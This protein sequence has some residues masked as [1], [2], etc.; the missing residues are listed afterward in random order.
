MNVWSHIYSIQ[1]GKIAIEFDCRLDCKISISDD[2]LH[3]LSFNLQLNNPLHIEVTPELK[4]L[5]SIKKGMDQDDEFARDD[6]TLI[7]T[8]EET[9]LS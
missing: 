6:E 3:L 5:V 1:I 7:E 2:V 4:V 9:H 8:L